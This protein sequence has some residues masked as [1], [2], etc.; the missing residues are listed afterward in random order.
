M[1]CPLSLLVSFT[2]ADALVIVLINNIH[3]CVH[4][5]V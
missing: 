3:A 4:L 1:T 2:V 5:K